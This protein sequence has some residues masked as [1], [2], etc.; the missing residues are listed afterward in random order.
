MPQ[1][2]SFYIE[3]V[4][5]KRKFKRVLSKVLS[6]STRLIYVDEWQPNVLWLDWEK[7]MKK[8]PT[9]A[10]GI[11][12]HVPREFSCYVEIS[13]LETNF[14]VIPLHEMYKQ[15]A[16]LLKSKLIVDYPV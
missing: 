9:I 15:L 10:V 4:T 1:Q 2:I 11:Y 3:K 16:K 7:I 5:T 8:P 14:I 13:V 12:N 6:I